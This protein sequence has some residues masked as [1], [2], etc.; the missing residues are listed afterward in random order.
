VEEQPLTLEERIE[1][2]ESVRDQA[3]DYRDQ[4]RALAERFRRRIG[5]VR[6]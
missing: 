4:M 5:G 3:E 2:L 1:L 6:T